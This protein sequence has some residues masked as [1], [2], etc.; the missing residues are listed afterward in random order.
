MA[1]TSGNTAIIVL[2]T[3]LTI[4][5]LCGVLFTLVLCVFKM[6]PKLT[7]SAL[8]DHQSGKGGSQSES[9]YE[10]VK[11]VSTQM[12]TNLIKNVAYGCALT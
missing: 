10:D 3:L 5:I 9:T 4:I 8:Q 2:S 7:S 11:K 12:E 6:K 1:G